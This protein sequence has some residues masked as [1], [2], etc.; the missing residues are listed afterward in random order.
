MPFLPPPVASQRKGLRG[1]ELARRIAADPVW[2]AKR[3]LEVDLWPRQ[4]EVVSAPFL[5]KRV[6]VR[7]CVASTKTFAAAVAALA[8]L[9]GHPRTGRVIHLAPSFRQVDKNMWGYIKQLEKRAE[10]NGTPLGAKMY[11]DPRMEFGPGWDYTG[12]S[13]R[14]PG[15]VHG[16]HGPDDLIVLDDAHGIPKSLTDELENMFAGGNTHLMMLFN[17]VVLSG[18]TYDCTHSL[19]HLYH[20]IKISFADL[21]AAYAAGFRM[22]GALQPET[23]ALW[24]GKYGKSSSFYLPKV[25]AEYPGQEADT[26]LPMD[27]VEQA[28]EREVPQGGAR[29]VGCDVAWEGDD[30]SVIAPMTGRQVHDLEEYHGQDPME[31]ADRLDVHLVQPGVAGF[32]DSIGIGAGVYSR[33]AQRG[34]T[35]TA[36]NVAESAVGQWEGKEAS[37]HFLNL[38]AQ[39]AWVL[40]QALDPKNPE[41]IALPRDLEMQAQM[42]AIKYKINA[43]GK[44]QLQSKKDMKKA[45][46]YSPDK[47]D[48]V[49]LAVWGSRGGSS[50]DAPW[51]AW[52]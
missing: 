29:V 24:A 3:V 12:F 5:H 7:G 39:V 23:V 16:I 17:P 21:E 2:F 6:A 4:A 37:D 30:D 48:A 41:A 13:T 32:V 15:N 28:M 43:G 38:R 1:A 22:P 11:V 20:N 52:L 46:G 50:V 18:E 42:S 35:V 51:G 9:L 47:F 19:S 31:V 14:D 44:V 27:W 33:E 49:A 26:L 45:L 34:R 36:V 10:E 25:D 40:R 8:W